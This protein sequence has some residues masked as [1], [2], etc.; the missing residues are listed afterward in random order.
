[1]HTHLFLTA[2]GEHRVMAKTASMRWKKLLP[3]LAGVTIAG[4]AD[5]TLCGLGALNPI[6]QA[7]A[8]KLHAW[9]LVPDDCDAILYADL[10]IYPQ[11]PVPPSV[12]LADVD[13]AC[14]RDRWDDAEVNR[15]ADA[16]GLPRHQYFNAG[17]FYARRAA[18]PMMEAA[19]LFFDR[20]KWYDQTGLN[21]AR[22]AHRTP[23]AWL[24]WRVNAMDR[25]ADGHAIG[26]SHCPD[27]A[28]PAWKLGE[29]RTYPSLPDPHAMI[30]VAD[31]SH[32]FAT[33]PEHLHA[34]VNVVDQLN[35]HR[36]ILEVGTF[37]GHAS[38]PLAATGALVTTLD[39]AHQVSTR[40]FKHGL[41]IDAMAHTGSEW[42]AMD[43]DGIYDM[44][45]HDAE[46][47]PHIIPELEAWWSR[48]LPGGVLAVHDAEQLEG[49]RGQTLPTKSIRI[50]IAPD[51]RGRELLMLRK[52]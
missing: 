25:H 18:A 26:C 45:F 38:W 16:I 43:L 3:E 41:S 9:D 44:I 5:A 46:H 19:S 51:S 47:G 36:H 11:D 28:W 7:C 42:L 20:L 13:F 35:V 2:T 14:V 39:P 1:M 52:V 34:M 23:T 22:Y 48:L 12:A 27:H 30:D 37:E 15:V 33:A 21:L 40:L 50:S 17:L 49:W 32:P 6:R 4:D 8:L 24:P 10:D 29:G 31:Y